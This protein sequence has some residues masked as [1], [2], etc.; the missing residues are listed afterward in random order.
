MMHDFN[1][2]SGMWSEIQLKGRGGERDT[3]RRIKGRK[4]G[5][6]TVGRSGGGCIPP[7]SLLSEGFWTGEGRQG[8]KG[9]GGWRRGERWS[10]GEGPV[11]LLSASHVS[12]PVL[13]NE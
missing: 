3:C 9:S 10:E 6:R 2:V 1:S 11:W 5:G 4:R 13:K 8:G 7:H 12:K